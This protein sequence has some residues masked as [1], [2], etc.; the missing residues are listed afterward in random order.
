LAALAAA[1]VLCMTAPSA[2]AA[3]KKRKRAGGTL[4]VTKVVNAPIPDRGPTAAGGIHGLLASTI[5]V[6]KEFK[7]R[8]IR[9]VNVTVQTLG[10][11]AYMPNSSGPASHL[12]GILRAPDGA[13]TTLFNGL[14]PPINTVTFT[15]PPNPSIGP[16]TLDDESPL[17]LGNFDPTNPTRLYRPWAG[18]A[19]PD[20]K[21]LAV[22]DNGPARGTWTLQVLDD[23]NG[24]T[25]NLV[26]WTLRVAT[27]RPFETK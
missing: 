21:A 1:L 22:M 8:R 4:E 18:T 19:R 27:G 6:G 14:F 23:Q 3:K 2:D 26:Q 9:D 16:L 13:H 20:G 10:A 15:S 11:T 17:G 7:G 12:Q 5:D 24:E 25:S